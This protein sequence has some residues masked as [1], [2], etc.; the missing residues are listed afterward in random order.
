MP[1]PRVTRPSLADRRL[2][3]ARGVARLG[4]PLGRTC[5]QAAIRGALLVSIA[6]VLAVVNTAACATAPC[7]RER[8]PGV[9]SRT[10]MP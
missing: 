3:E 5:A 4:R 9:R 8:V 2:R 10:E 7:T 6:S 1:S